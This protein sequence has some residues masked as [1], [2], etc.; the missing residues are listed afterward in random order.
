MLTQAEADDLIAIQKSFIRASTVSISS[1]TDLTYDLV[2]EDKR[3]YFLLDLWRGTL[4][5]SKVKY[6]TRGRKVFILVRLDI[7]SAPHT[8]PDGKKVGNSHIH[9][10][11][12]G[13]EDKWAYPIDPEKFHNLSDMGCTFT[14]FCQYCNIHNPPSFQGTLI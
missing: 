12:E 4:K 1:G 13:F 11:R 2:S 10:Y 5:F 6:Q 8:N 14:E 3:E 7:N 9:I